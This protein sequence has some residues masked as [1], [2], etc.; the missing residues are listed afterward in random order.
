MRFNKGNTPW[1]K[2]LK[3]AN[4]KKHYPNGIPTIFKKGGK[5]YWLGKKRP[6]FK[7][8]HFFK[9]G[10]KV[11]AKHWNWNGGKQKSGN[12]YIY[13]LKPDHPNADKKGRVPEHRY[14]MEQYLKRRLKREEIIHH[15]NGNRT[16]NRIENLK[17]MSHKEHIRLEYK[18]KP[19]NTRP[20]NEGL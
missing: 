8:P 15:I 9:K 2:G 12:G 19:W 11:G 20:K 18:L 5:G 1:N 14:V 10:E 4:Y 3:G 7:L 13:I 16:D 6:N 17:I